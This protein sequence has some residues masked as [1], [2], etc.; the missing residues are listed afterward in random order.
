[1]VRSI[2]L[3]ALA[4]LLA[5]SSVAQAA[6]PEG[7]TT[8]STLTVSGHGEIAATPDQAVVRL[9]AVVQA[10]EAASAQKQVNQ[11][12]ER[13]IK[14]VRSL[15]IP[16]EM[17]TTSGLTLEPVYSHSK[18]AR[19]PQASRII[20]YRASNTIL[21]QTDDLDKIGKVIDTA[22]AAGA[23]RI[24]GLAFRLRN[25]SKFRQQ[26]LQLAVKEARAKAETIASAMHVRIV[27]VRE[28]SETGGRVMRPQLQMAKAYTANSAT[29]VQPGQ[30]QVEAGVTVRYQIAPMH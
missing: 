10:A 3:A 29:P 14:Q 23:N 24:E 26:A 30:I 20:G 5:S 19:E 18:P 17:I 11:I 25:D 16:P 7:E 12:M 2:V 15:T 13:A 22:V 21:V 1:M 27:A 6:G 8:V 4:V 9:G 28:I